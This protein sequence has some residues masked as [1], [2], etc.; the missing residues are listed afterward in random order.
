MKSREYPERPLVGVGALIVDDSARVLV[1]LRA[2]EPLKGQWSLPGGLVKIGETLAEAL[3]R[4]VREETGLDVEVGAVVE[5]LDRIIP[6]RITPERTTSGPGISKED[7][8]ASAEAGRVRFHFVLIDYLCHV[9]GGEMRAA[10]DVTDV[11]WATLHETELLGIADYTR[12]V[13][14]KALAIGSGSPA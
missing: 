7:E 9:I 13:I 3:R 5:V 10:S 11:R 6:E 12:E 1:V 4:E 2:N 8:A 14:A